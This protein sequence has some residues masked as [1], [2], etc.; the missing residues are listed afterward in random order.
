M[1]CIACRLL[2]R[3]VDKVTLDDVR[4]KID[5]EKRR[6]AKFSEKQAQKQTSQERTVNQNDTSSGGSSAPP[7]PVALEAKMSTDSVTEVSM[8]SEQSSSSVTVDSR[9]P[10]AMD[11]VEAGSGTSSSMVV[12]VSRG[13]GQNIA[14]P[15]RT[16]AGL[17]EGGHVYMPGDVTKLNAQQQQVSRNV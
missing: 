1:Y 5:S 9:V 3:A 14:G 13:A 7:T 4:K 16:G 11:V 15:S 2:H 6:Q 8:H 10:E 12:D 17:F